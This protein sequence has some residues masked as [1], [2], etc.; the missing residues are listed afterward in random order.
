[1]SPLWHAEKVRSIHSRW[2]YLLNRDGTQRDGTGRDGAIQL[3]TD[4]ARSRRWR[5]NHRWAQ[6]QR[7]TVGG[8]LELSP[9]S[10]G[11]CTITNQRTTKDRHQIL[12]HKFPTIEVTPVQLR[13]PPFLSSLSHTKSYSQ[14]LPKER[15]FFSMHGCFASSRQAE[16]ASY[17]NYKNVFFV[18]Q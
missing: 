12:S 1:M 2:T 6:T 16:I 4:S 9:S 10:P 14:I 7:K 5:S 3:L 13:R 17:E 11:F 15:M 8:I 18:V